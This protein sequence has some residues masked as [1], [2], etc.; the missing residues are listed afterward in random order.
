MQARRKYSNILKVWKEKNC[1]YG[2]L[3]PAKICLKS[4]GEI[5]SLSDIQKLKK[6]H[7]WLTHTTRN[8]IGSP[9]DKK[10]SATR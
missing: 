6:I 4:E 5:K 3:Y 9:S 2:I 8:T 7:Y 1:K 10:S